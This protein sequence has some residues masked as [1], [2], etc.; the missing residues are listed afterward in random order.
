MQTIMT[1]IGIGSNLQSPKTQ[2]A[3][4]IDALKKIPNIMLVK[5]SSFYQSPPL[6]PQ[7]Q[8]DFINCVV[9][10]ETTL[11]PLELLKALQDIE[12]HQGR[13]RKERWGTRI[14]DLDILLY[15]NEIID[16][17]N[18]TIPHPGLKTRAF[19]VYPLAEINPDLFLPT[20]ES[21]IDL[22]SQLMRLYGKNCNLSGDL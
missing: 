16:L 12:I 6:G 20:G 17:P 19:V 4:A 2:V 13:V 9:A 10:C 21:V 5:I 18:L 15:G 8:P 3:A 22:H 14:I 1:Y 7:N 11:T